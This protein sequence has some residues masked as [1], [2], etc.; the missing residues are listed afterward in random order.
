MIWPE[1]V[2]LRCPHDTH[3]GGI[4]LGDSVVVVIG[5]GVLYQ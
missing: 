1:C 4:R 3:R 5:F 2:S